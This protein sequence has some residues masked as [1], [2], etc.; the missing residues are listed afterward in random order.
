MKKKI[1]K[2]ISVLLPKGDLKEQ[3]KLFYYSLL[4]SGMIGF[5][6]KKVNNKTVYV[7]TTNDIQVNTYEALYPIY[8]DFDYY[9]HFYKVSKDDVVVDAGAN[10]GHLSIFFAKLVG[11][12]G[13]IFAFEPD[14]YNIE[15]I[16]KNMALNSEIENSI[17]IEDLLLWNTNEL[18]DFQES[19]TVGSSAVWKPDAENCIKKQAVTI[20]SWV[21]INNIQKL[22]FIKMDIEGAEIEALAGCIETI[23]KL[24]PNFAI[25]TYHIVNNE[26]TYIRVEQFFES[27][28]YPYKTV[29]FRGNETITF[30]GSLVR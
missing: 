13:K 2:T 10:C 3:L 18:I 9:Q 24:Q 8:P 23:K 30:A 26:K 25:A 15:R 21:L 1:K 29:T 12:Q 4:K 6:L 16:K 14:K 20:D 7:T 27:L 17:V 11:K 5:A 28:H 22:D 19:G